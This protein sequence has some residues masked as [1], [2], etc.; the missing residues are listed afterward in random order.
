MLDADRSVRTDLIKP[1]PVEVLTDALVEAGTANRAV[2]AAHCG[3]QGLPESFLIMDRWGAT[4]HRTPGGSG[5][6]E[7]DVMVI[8]ASRQGR[9]SRFDL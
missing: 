8:E 9:A 1:C 5:C 7:M 2:C 3:K 4:H 6:E